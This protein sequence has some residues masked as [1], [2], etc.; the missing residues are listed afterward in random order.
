MEMTPISQRDVTVPMGDGGK[1][2]DGKR[3]LPGPQK[4]RQLNM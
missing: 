2:K 1:P 3:H 4:Q